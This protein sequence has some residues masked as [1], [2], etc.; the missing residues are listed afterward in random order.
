MNM[1]RMKWI[2][3]LFTIIFIGAFEFVRH[4]F[5][6]FISM[7]WGNLLVAV[8]TGLLFYIYFHGVFSLLENLYNKL[9]KEQEERAVWQERERIARELHDSVSQ[10]LFF[11][12][13]KVLEIGTALKEEQR[14]P[15]AAVKE[16]QEAIKITDKDVRQH[17]F[18]LQKITHENIN[19]IT[20][21]QK[22]I[23]DYETQNN[24]KVKLK[25]NGDINS[26]LT[27]SIRSQLFR[28]FQELLLNIRKHAEAKQV[29]I[30]LLEDGKYFSMII[31]DSGKGFNTENLR[32]NEM[33]F[34]LKMLEA[35][36]YAIGAKL[37]VQSFPEKGTTV[38]V[39]LELK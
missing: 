16:L 4:H 23:A 29:D 21:F 34:G 37:N 32:T 10:A 24:I 5:L 31:Q 11:M 2:T 33:S 14:G 9:Q 27:N 20:V 6:D 7:S 28:I 30:S 17:I 39:S 35:D 25:I 22:Y 15:L 13:V 1:K 38:T 19:L 26:K 12:N 3:A 8:V 18:A 36:V